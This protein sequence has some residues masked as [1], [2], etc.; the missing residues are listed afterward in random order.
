MVIDRSV[1]PIYEDYINPTTPHS[2]PF[3]LPALITLKDSISE[4]VKV[5]ASQAE[6]IRDD[7]K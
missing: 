1:S 2:T 6:D 7:Y 4:T 3:P 5:F